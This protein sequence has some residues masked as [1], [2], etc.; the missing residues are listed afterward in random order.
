MVRTILTAVL[1]LAWYGVFAQNGTVSPYSFF[2]IG[3][4]RS[5]ATVENEAMGRLQLYADSIH[6]NLQN[7][8]AYGQLRLTT[9]TAGIS[10]KELRIESFEEK[11]NSSVT[12]LNYLAM[13]IPLGKKWGAGFG[14][15][16]YS[17]VGYN[18]SG[19][20]I[21][22]EGNE[23]T[24]QYNGQGGINKVFLSLGFEP[25]KNLTLGATLNYN[26]GELEHLREQTVEG[27]QFG[28]LDFRSSQVDGYDFNYGA[29][30]RAAASDK[31]TLYASV[32]VNT[33]VNLV[34]RNDQRVGSFNPD[35]GR[36]IEV[37]DVDLAR[38]GDDRTEIKVPTITTLGLGYGEEKKWFLGAEYSMQAFS[39]FRNEFMDMEEIEY[40]DASSIGFGGYYIPDYRSFTDF[41][42][43]VVY[44]A[45]L[46]LDNTGM[47]IRD[48]EISNFGITFGL[49]IPLGNEFSN[50]NIG[51]EAGRRGTTTANLVRES[52][53]KLNIGLSLN[54]K[55]FRKRVID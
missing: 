37:F 31:H 27:V 7:P 12:N 25:I 29:M 13:G 3:D 10:H 19:T 26:F 4:I 11:Q 54:A 55:W 30:Y 9:Y 40:R 34:A 33:Q 17:S 21:N 52:Y 39:E 38:T 32:S 35:T 36:D 5:T 46:R 49:G 42:S 23:V 20:S 8:A 51:L 28:T 24:N 1:C 22:S 15:V 41:F 16:P 48:K 44:R 14:L 43:R 45:G 47:V 2:G 6:V 18:L 50:L 53:F